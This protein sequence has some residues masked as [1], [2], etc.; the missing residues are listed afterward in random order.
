MR[1][2]RDNTGRQWLVNV[3]VTTVRRPEPGGSRLANLAECAPV[4]AGDVVKLADTLLA[5]CHDEARER[6]LDADAFGAAWPVT[7]WPRPCRP[8]CRPRR[9]LS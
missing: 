2:F 1:T 3:N 8:C 9:I 7:A 5:V 4:L 6:N